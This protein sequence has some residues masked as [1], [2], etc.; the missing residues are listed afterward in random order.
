MKKILFVLTLIVSF[1][2]YAQINY[3]LDGT[4]G[5]QNI[6]TCSGKFFDTGGEGTATEP[7]SYYP[8]NQRD[9]I[10]FCSDFPGKKFVSFVRIFPCKLGMCFMCMTVQRLIQQ[11]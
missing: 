10:T 11:T 1:S 3:L 9:T 8:N 5:I 6:V 7:L 4:P 2:S